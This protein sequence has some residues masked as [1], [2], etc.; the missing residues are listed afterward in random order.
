[1]VVVS[2]STPSASSIVTSNSALPGA[3]VFAIAPVIVSTTGPDGLGKVPSSPE[4][5]EGGIVD[6]ARK[7]ANKQQRAAGAPKRVV[8]GKSLGIC[9][10]R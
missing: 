6:R 3:L 7:A 4:A 5:A 2:A 1:M 10:K 8:I 9:G